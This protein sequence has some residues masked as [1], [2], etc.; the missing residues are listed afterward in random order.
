MLITSR[1]SPDV[2]IFRTT[3]ATEGFHS[4]LRGMLSRKNNPPDRLCRQKIRDAMKEFKN[5][6][7]PGSNIRAVTINRYCRTMSRYVKTV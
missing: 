7:K 1:T 6:W 2:D 5:E 3:K 4:K